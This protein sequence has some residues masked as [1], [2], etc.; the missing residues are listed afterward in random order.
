MQILR[1][2][3]PFQI[4]GYVP[5]AAT[6]IDKWPSPDGRWEIHLVT[7]THPPLH[8][9]YGV[10]VIE[11]PDDKALKE[12]AGAPS[13]VRQLACFGMDIFHREAEPM[14]RRIFED[15]VARL[16]ARY[17]QATGQPIEQTEV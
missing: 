16:Q 12:D 9:H 7:G 14:A 8:P 13:V 10:L 3:V 5:D 2:D 6:L 1:T 4:W 17:D 15:T 11:H